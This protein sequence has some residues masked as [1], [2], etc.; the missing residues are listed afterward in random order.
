M[1]CLHFQQILEMLLQ[2]A[3]KY[4][5]R[6]LSLQYK[7]IYQ[8][9]QEL[10]KYKIAQLLFLVHYKIKSQ[11]KYVFIL[12]LSLYKCLFILQKILIQMV[13]IRIGT[14]IKCGC[15]ACR[16]TDHVQF[17]AVTTL[18]ILKQEVL[19]QKVSNICQ[20]LRVKLKTSQIS[21]KLTISLKIQ[22][23]LNT[24]QILAR[25]AQFFLKNYRFLLRRKFRRLVT[26]KFCLCI[27][28]IILL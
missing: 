5:L 13:Q 25:C 11:Q 12:K 26:V 9:S 6:Q 7:Y 17:K 24:Q 22:T 14:A 2:Y 4:N 18:K 16:I 27:N 19:G 21:V 8:M 3:T 23:I 28:L 15:F 20:N 1:Q 10:I